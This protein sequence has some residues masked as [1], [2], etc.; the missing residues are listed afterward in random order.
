MF[1]EPCSICQDNRTPGKAV[2]VREVKRQTFTTELR[3]VVFAL[4]DAIPR[5]SPVPRRRE[6]PIPLFLYSKV[7]SSEKTRR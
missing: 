3:R 5:Q 2:S 4:N 6:S 1:N 7:V